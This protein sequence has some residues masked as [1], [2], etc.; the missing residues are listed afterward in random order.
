MSKTMKILAP[1]AIVLVSLGVAAIIV[2]SKPDVKTAP[3]E[4]ARPFVRAIEVQKQN[5]AMTVKSQGNVVPRTESTL[6]SEVAGRVISVSPGFAA[7]GFFEQGD[8]LVT[9]DKRDYE[10]AL[11]QAKAQVAQAEMRWKWENQEAEVAKK[12]WQRLGNNGTAPDLVLRKPQLAEAEAAYAAAQ[13]A[14]QQAE[15]NLERTQI[16]APYAGRVRSKLVDVGQFVNPGL[17]VAQIYAVDWAEVRL[18][19]PDEELAYLDMPLNFR[20]G[21]SENHGSEVILRGNFAGTSHEWRGY[22]AR[23][24]G[25]IDARSRMVY[26][27]ARVENPYGRSHDNRPPLAVGMFVQAEIIGNTINDLITLPRSA[28]RDNNQV[29]VV[30]HLN[31]LRF[32]DVEI[33]RIDKETAF[34]KAGLNNGETVCISPLE[35]V[36]DGM[37]VRIFEDENETVRPMSQEVAQ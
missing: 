15:L 3:A 17:P 36:V 10:L 14:M 33:F 19:L 27:V 26:A 1:I 22:I 16:R 29:L 18:P 37:H 25:E 34:I 32:R 35:T 24:E 5:I 13:A 20:G 11:T 4:I 23:M 21:K 9:V 6:V 28:L 7:G 31:Q 8:V 30:D 2:V 12:E